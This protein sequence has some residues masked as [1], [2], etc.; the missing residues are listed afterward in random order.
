[1]PEAIHPM[2]NSE[3]GRKSSLIANVQMVGQTERKIE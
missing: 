3:E 2:R 1:M